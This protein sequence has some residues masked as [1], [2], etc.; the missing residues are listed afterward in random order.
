MIRTVKPVCHKLVR[1][2]KMTK[3]YDVYVGRGSMWGNMY[4]HIPNIPHTILVP[5]RTVAIGMYKK[6]L[7]KPDNA[8][9]LAQVIPQLKGKTLGCYCCPQACHASILAYIANGGY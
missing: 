7:F 3:E 1:N 9:I 6:W 4:T 5:N 8:H 2:I